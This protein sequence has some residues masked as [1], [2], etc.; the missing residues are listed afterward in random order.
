MLVIYVFDLI[1]LDFLLNNARRTV[2]IMKLVLMDLLVSSCY[3]LSW[4]N[5]IELR[6][7]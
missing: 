7:S 6:P 3:I 2:R 1:L 5:Y 4:K